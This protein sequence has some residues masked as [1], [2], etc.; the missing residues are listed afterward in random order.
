M[1]LTSTHWGTYQ[2]KVEQGRI[3]DMQPFS[4]DPDPSDIGRGFIDV[5]DAPSRIT[6][7]MVRKGWLERKGLVPSARRGADSYVEVDWQTALD[8]VA[9]ELNRVRTDYGNQAIYAGCYG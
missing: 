2:P 6:A 7:P 3:T 5:L 1:G 9:G 8:L 4:E